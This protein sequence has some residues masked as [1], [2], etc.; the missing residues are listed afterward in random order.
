[1]H[2]RKYTLA[3][4]VLLLFLLCIP[5]LFPALASSDE[6]Y[7][8]VDNNTS[9]VDANPDK[10]AHS[11][12][13]AQKYGPDSFYDT[14]SEENTGGTGA[15]WWFNA[16]DPEI[17]FSNTAYDEKHRLEFNTQANGDYLLIVTFA[18]AGGSTS[19]SVGFRAQ[20][21]DSTTFMEGLFEPV[22]THGSGE[23]R[24]FGSFYLAQ[25]L[26]FG[27]HHVDLDAFGESASYTYYMKYMHITVL[28][29]DDWLPTN[30]MYEYVSTDTEASLPGVN[31]QYIDA[32]T[33]TFTPDQAGDYLILASLEMRSGYT[34]DSVSARLNYDSGVE[35]LPVNNNEEAYENYVTYESKDTTDYLPFIWGGIVNIPTSP[36]TIKLQACRTG[37]TNTNGQVRRSR[38]IAIRLGAMDS[39]VQYTEDTSVTSTTSSWTDKSTL[40]FT[41]TSQ[42]D[43]LILGAMV[44]KPD[45]TSYPGHTRLEHAS[46]TNP[47]TID[48]AEIDS[49][50]SGNPADCIPFFTTEM[51][52]LGATSQT[53]KTQ[54]G[55]FLGSGTTYGKGSFIVAIRKPPSPNYE[56]DLEVQW[57]NATY[58]LPN[59]ELCI[60]G[61]AM[62]SENLQV[63]VWN[64]SEWQNLFTDLSNGWNNISVTDYLVSPTFTIRFQGGTETGDNTQSSWQIDTTL[65]HVWAIAPIANF[66][67]TPEY[68][69]TDE[70]IIFNASTSYDPDGSIISY[71]W[72]FGD[73]TNGTDEITTHTYPDDG[74]Y[75]VTLTV[76]DNHDLTSTDFQSITVLNR[77]P[78]ASF[79]ESATSVPTGTPI[80]FNASDSYDPDG[81]IV[82]YFWDFG[83]GTNSTGLTTE[84][85]YL[86]NGIYIVTL[87]VTDNDSARST[88]TAT[89]TIL[90]R[91]PTASFTENA[92]TVYTGE[93]IQFNASASFDPDGYITSYF[94]DF[95]DGS[96]VTGVEVSHS[97]TDDGTY[98]VTLTVT[99]DDG[100]TSTSNAT[101]IILNRPPVAGFTE[102]AETVYTGQI[103]TFNASTSYDLDG[104]IVSYFWD[105]GDGTNATGI[106]VNHAYADDGTYNVTLTVTDDDGATAS[107]TATKTVLN[108]PPVASF[109][110]SATTVYKGEV[111]HF[112]ASDSYD[113]DGTIVS[114]FWDFGDGTNGTGMIIDH[115][116]SNIGNYI[117]M[118]TVTDDDGATAFSNA[119][120]TV[121]SKPPVANFSESATIVYTDEFIDFNASSSYDPDGVIVSYF[122]DFGDGTNGTGVIVSYA[123]ADNGNYT[124]T[125][126]VTDDDGT[127]AASNATKTVLNRSPVASFTESAETVYTGEV[128]VFNASA[129]YDPDGSIVSYE[130]NFGDENITTV[131]TPIVTHAYADNGTYTVTLTV[132][133]DDGA[134]NSSLSIKTVLNRS[135]TA[136]FTFSPST[137]YTSETVVFDA[138]ASYDS[139]GSIVSYSWD[140]G[141][142]NITIVTTPTITHRYSD[143]GTYQITLTVT[144]DDGAEDT[145]SQSITVLNQSPVA[146]FTESATTVFTNEVIMFNAS[147]SY[148]PDGSIV[149]YEWNFGDG[150]NATGVTTNH[151]YA[152]DGVY[153]VTLT[154]TDNDGATA[155]ET[156]TKTVLN[157]PPI[158]SFT[159]SATI[160]FTG[161]I[162]YF[163]ASTSYDP[164]GTI[165]SYFWDFGDGTNATGETTNH[166]YVDDGTYMVTLTVTDNDGATTSTNA[167]KTV[168]NRPPVAT[169]TESADTV[170]TNEVILF[171]ASDS[172]DPDG[173][174]VSHFWDFGD[175]SNATGIL[176]NHSYAD[177][178]IYTVTLTVTDDDGA[179]DTATATKTVLNRPPVAVFTESAET[180][181][182]GETITF[183]A[184]DSY[185]P[186]GYIATF[187]WDF[188]DGTN[189]TGI[190]V[191]HAYSTNGTYIVTLTVTDN[192]GASNSTSS[193]KTIL[194]NEPPVA[195]FTESAET[196]YTGES[197]YFNASDSYDPDGTIVSYFWD[198]GDG[199]NASG[200]TVDHAYVDDGVYTVTL[201]VTDDRDATSSTNATKTVL[202]RSPIAS[203]TE[204]AETVYTGESI[205]FNATSSYDPDGVI[206][207]YWWEFGDGTNASGVTVNHAYAD[208]GVYNVILTVTDDDGATATSTATK[209]ILNRAPIAS[210][211]E[212]ATTVYTN[213][214]INFNAS[215]SYDPDGSIIIYFWDFGDSTN[216]TG[217]T[218]DHAYADDGIYT[219]TL[220]VTDND[221]TTGTTTAT[222]TVMNRLPVALFT[223]NATTV[224]TGEAIRFNASASYDPDGTIISYFWDFGDSTNA[225]GMIVDHT[226]TDNGTYTVT[227]TVTD[228]D[229]ATDTETAVKTVLNRPPVAVFTESAETVYTAETITFNASSS[230]DQDGLIV[231]YFWDFGDDTNTTGI[232]VNHAYADDGTYIVTLTVTD[233]DGAIATSS[234]TKTVLNR[235]PVAIFTESAESVV[236]GE[237]IYFNASTSY[238]PDGSIVSYFW[239]FGD[240]TNATGVTTEHAYSDN[241][242]YIVTLTV[243]DNDGAT[244][245]TTATKTVEVT[246]PVAIF[247]ES[248]EVVYTNEVITFDAS[249]SYDP[250]GYIVDY[251]WYFGDDTN[252]TG[253]IVQ[254]AYIEDGVYNVTLTVT[255]DDGA[256]DSA[257]AT[258][259]V[260]NQPPVALF[261][262]SAETVLTGEVIYFNASQSYDPDGTIVSYFWDFDDG[263]NATGVTVN[264]AYADNGT[265]TV[266]LTVT[267]NDSATG[268]VTADKTIL[269]QPPV[270]SFTESA[271][272][273]YTAEV[274]LFNAS[275]S[276]DSDGLIIGYFWDFG[277]GTN[278]SGVT[279][280]HAYT[281]DGVYTVI[282]T[283][284]DD[285]GATATANAVKTV[286][287]RS[288]VAI[289]TESAEV[290]YTNE[291]ITF[292]ASDSY[293]PDG[294]IIS[295]FWTFGDGTN[296]TGVIVQHAYANDGNYTVTLTVTDDDGATGT[297][298]SIKT[299]LNRV[300]SATFS[301]TPD[302]PIAGETVTFNASE[303]YDSD[304]LIIGYFWD[305]G[306]GSPFLNTTNPYATHSYSILGNY[307][308]TL[309]VTDD[310]GDIDTTIQIVRVRDYPNAT[311]TYSPSPPTED[312]TVTFNASFSVPNGGVIT[313]YFWDFGDGT[314]TVNTTNPITTHI[315]ST[316]GNYT[317][318]LT[319][320]DSEGLTDTA[321]D[322]IGVKGYPYATFTFSPSYPIEGETVTLDASASTP[323]GG[324]ITSYQWNFGDGNITTIATP[325]ITHVYLS[326]G[327]YTV[328]LTVTDSEGLIDSESQIVSVRGYPLVIFSYTPETP[329]VGDSVT[330][331]ASLSDPNGGVIVSY[332]WN[333]GDG[334]PL[335]N[336]T[337]PFVTHIYNFAGNYNVTLTIT[338][339]EGLSN[340]E[341]HLIVVAKAPIASF[342][343]SPEFPKVD[344]TVTFNASNSYDPNG[345]VANYTWDFGDGNIT[346]TTNPLI[347]HAYTSTGVY[348]VILTITDNDGY[349]DT[350]TDTVTLGTPE[351][352][353]TYSPGSPIAEQ[354]ITFNASSSYD[355]NGYIVSYVWNFGD[356]NITTVTN[357]I[358]TH[359][360]AVSGN[361]TVSLTVADN[362]GLTDT[363]THVISVGKSP[364]A[365]FTYTPSIPYVGDTLTFNASLSTPGSGN[366]T[367][368]LWNFGDGSPLL[369]TTNPIITHK[370][371][372]ARNYTVSLTIKDSAELTN[373]ETKLVTILQSPVANFI[374]SPTYPQAFDTVTFNASNSYDANGYIVSYVWNFGDGNITSAT[375]PIITHSYTDAGNYT[376]ILTVADNEGYTHTTIHSLYVS[377]RPPVADFTSMPS[378][379][380]ADQSVTFN[381]SNSYDLDGTIVSYKWDFGDGNT[382]TLTNPLVT[383][384]YSTAGNYTVILTVT[385][386]DN[387]TN[388]K[389]STLRIRDYPTANF[390]YIPSIPDVNST[391]TFNASST[392]PNGGGILFYLWDFGDG[393]PLLNTTNPIAT[394]VFS[395]S[396][397]YTITLTVTDSEGLDD[398]AQHTIYVAE[399][400]TALFT[401]SP[402]QPYV[403]DTITFNAS[404]SYALDGYIVSYLWDFG[405]GS[406]KINTT[407][408]ITTYIYSIGKNYSVTLTVFDNLGLSDTVSH[409]ANVGKAPA[410]V[411]VYSPDFPI[412]GEV[413]T[414]NASA[415]NDVRRPIANYTWDFGDGNIITV[416]TPV[417]THVYAQEGN[418]VISLT[419]TDSEGY[420]DTT[421]Q[422]INIRNYPIAS[423]N[424]APNYPIKEQDATFDATSSQPRGGIITSYLWNFGDGTPSINTTN[425]TIKH[426]YIAVGQYNVTLTI[427]DSEGL[428]NTT[429][430]TLKVR[431]YPTAEFTWAPPSP[432]TTQSV[433][434]NASLSTANSGSITGFMWEFGDGRISTMPGSIPTIQHAY[435]DAGNYTVKLT[436]YNSEGLSSSISKIVTVLNAPPIASFEHSPTSPIAGQSVTFNASGS[437][438]LDG[439]I[440]SYKWDFD[441]G[442]ITTVTTS[443]IQHVYATI[444]NLTVT[445]TVTDDDGLTAT[446]AKTLRIITYP[447]ADFM[448]SPQTPRSTESVTFNASTSLPNS[449]FIASYLWNF[450]DGHTTTVTT[451]I[452]THAYSKAKNYTVTLTVINSEG[453]SDEESHIIT[454]VGS[455]PTANFTWQPALPSVDETVNFDAS[456]SKANGGTIVGYSWN[457]GDGTPPT[458]LLFAYRIITH[459]FTSY[460]QFNVTLTVLDDEGLYDTESKMLSIAAPPHANFSWSPQSPQ[461]YESISFDASASTPNGGA[462]TSYTW[463]FGDGNITTVGSPTISHVFTA[464]GNYTV[465]LTV[466][467]SEG[468]SDSLS[469]TID[470]SSAPSP[471]A[472]Y[473]YSPPSPYV[474]EAV[475]FNASASTPGTGSIADYR[476]DFGDG[477][478]TSVVAPT[479]MHAYGV[480][481]NF[482]VVLTVTNTVGLSDTKST[483]VIILP[484]SGPTASF[485]WSPSV[486]QPNTTVTF[487]ASSSMPGWNGSMHPAI[488]SYLWDFG[489]GTNGTGVLVD[490]VYS[491]EG[492]YTVT[493]TVVDINGATSNLTGTITVST[494][495][496]DL[497][498]DGKVDIKD[499]AIVSK[500]Y[501]SQLGDPNWNPVADVNGDG[502]VD[503]KDVAIVASHYGETV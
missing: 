370:Y 52:Q 105:F 489:D 191:Q 182:V 197:I 159:E 135:P 433:T 56:L 411:F 218:V 248:A 242:V 318:I 17:S 279:V 80:Y 483:V 26:S 211:T 92:T 162:I 342:S 477:N 286:L 381:A 383:H 252:A 389:T 372:A 95:G 348:T 301:Y 13:T 357:P 449:G 373:T 138:S 124:V 223:E 474:F 147:A 82:S 90:N 393:S 63:D 332:L 157:Q 488:V 70:T 271:E 479:I 141:D 442:N 317:V 148:D 144:D 272:T 186:D 430:K 125:L 101:K 323:N 423:F 326:I 309:T 256:I 97:Y 207:S 456:S 258:K 53:F 350:L 458:P 322:T 315:Y 228:D 364:M 193:A 246:A 136:L 375:K 168:L 281:D 443:I 210:F 401:F 351:A 98:T 110:E 142:G 354:L 305:F 149:S 425:P 261:T 440:V 265:Y 316:F 172:Y 478:V 31:G 358:I 244:S 343:Y 407:N 154:V 87:N 59:E 496:G 409:I 2:K 502:K 417:L 79:T 330:F 293:D 415:S 216:A 45:S 371:T 394:H 227:L 202:N 47:E 50:D 20:L 404:Q 123:Y 282:L 484:I 140:F 308:V 335:L 91:A 220:T 436:V 438:D 139:D 275:Q 253:V 51:K 38:I 167:T 66:F 152:D 395:A 179:T 229:G 106:V 134:T 319:V 451:P 396:G 132:A 23:Y 334:S 424:Y 137:P 60:Y 4:L 274:I 287:N 374:H 444:G 54:Y 49:K 462:I 238:D 213:E 33:I 34:S 345:Y 204:S 181:Y 7:D 247:T 263:T 494:L 387:L 459:Q 208:D 353:F 481:G 382:T 398:T 455:P 397:N 48:M 447:T 88:A 498:G 255:D 412:A 19:Y 234:A 466:T 486:P 490:H 340:I 254:H 43:Y 257:T 413:V 463:N 37:G 426:T 46:G 75:N 378:F 205:A 224:L 336:T 164:D 221:G 291:V 306:D 356:G 283:V 11:N 434:F 480:S 86:D 376:V 158:A 448:W 128:I 273:V 155:N 194:R 303:S 61:G 28:R 333:F 226:Y 239:D 390:A 133:D 250:D 270:A 233:D 452:I 112:N 352:S 439:I 178:G 492:T 278:A 241:G 295:Y 42:E 445:L 183:N 475:T 212:S 121:L 491:E 380:V 276:Y 58:N 388:I 214:V 187:F 327:N 325:S 501:G 243:T 368:Y 81:W 338:D 201:T 14:I 410:A 298:T 329:Y 206:V 240:G 100:A 8:Y 165:V 15:S 41:P 500:A 259:T 143:N 297:A 366:I 21:D 217:V 65:L 200:L 437:Y 310:D 429:L 469:K 470:V 400:P 453:L 347:T 115:S 418:Y 331:N 166:A 311:F 416:N 355:P 222:K 116:Y 192:D 495:V 403:G 367:Y 78:V 131:L 67:Y 280:S 432:V 6:L 468:L 339:S 457:F 290:V 25:S 169:F 251:F 84:H 467:D 361:Y 360:Y 465:A 408:P 292:D 441:D 163:N 57:T 3:F 35:Y 288:P 145:A 289:F 341:V 73:G 130:W 406:P 177:N 126:T 307:T 174:I 320:A 300:P 10:G 68:P 277:D 414:F 503:I 363:T 419:V 188:G 346:T 198:F 485:T 249:D 99:D 9:D 24:S 189:T 32:Q 377:R 94:W 420:S 150:T 269:N 386:N 328:T 209:T 127:A 1:L 74:T 294:S 219:V 266:M 391:V 237:I 349:T 119:T 231:S 171:N 151:A 392:A 44:I 225:T 107:T 428:T 83:D 402:S 122:W 170:N 446:T 215:D 471:Q 22:A 245:S 5:L 175:G 337:N 71:F 365:Y 476:W 36:K 299:V 422:S 499:I 493:L 129:S 435:S 260:L 102:S 185:D 359:V 195:L 264:H 114:Y 236:V 369:N 405:D 184:S 180:A 313:S 314:P 62:G 302:F 296:A 64:G 89:K 284:T 267:D 109:T 16:S 120:K 285:D 454:V 156:A 199:S 55:R 29:L 93:T 427:T 230:Y 113:P 431:D 173:S 421:T 39:N 146:S 18:T 312:E 72:T 40:S 232:V 379:P 473:T 399:L 103:I 104:W 235:T 321:T 96:N 77:P 304:G 472:D 460:G 262:E 324:V 461:A 176:V 160:V 30:G 482:T 344:E 464:A 76:I 362:Q 450:G 487:D 196:V 85:A 118:L 12:F 108:R 385:D 384:Q 497:N 111:I 161:E 268:F 190:I 203:F 69:F 117:V 153:T 27:N